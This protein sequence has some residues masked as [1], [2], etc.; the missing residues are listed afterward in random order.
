IDPYVKSGGSN[1]NDLRAKTSIYVCPN[2]LVPAPLS[3][4][5]GNP[6]TNIDNTGDKNLP[7]GRWPLTSYAPN[8]S[9]TTAWWALGQSWAGE[10]ASVGTD[11]QV[12]KPSQQILLAPN[13]G[14]CI[15]TWGGGGANNWTEANRR[16]GDGANY[17]LVDGHAEWYHGS[18]PQYGADKNG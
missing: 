17:V 6:A 3:D 2:Y 14:C 10:N 13:H 11:A 15:E 5:A 7:V 18:N 8:F 4:E 1:S 9:T 16:H 12:G